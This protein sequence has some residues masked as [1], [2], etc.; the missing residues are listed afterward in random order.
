MNPIIPS[1]TQACLR[2]T[3]EDGGCRS[4]VGGASRPTSRSLILLYC[5]NRYTVVS[6]LS[7]DDESSSKREAEGNRMECVAR[8]SD[9]TMLSVKRRPALQRRLPR[10]ACTTLP[11]RQQRHL[12]SL[13]SLELVNP[14][15]VRVS[16]HAYSS[17][18]AASA[19]ICWSEIS[20]LRSVMGSECL[21]DSCCEGARK[22]RKRSAPEGRTSCCRLIPCMCGII[23][24]CKVVISLPA[25]F[26]IS[27]HLKLPSRHS[28]DVRAPD[29]VSGRQDDGSSRVKR[30]KLEP[31]SLMDGAIELYTNS[32]RFSRLR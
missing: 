17:A 27:L 19:M 23:S 26:L 22:A 6:V 5:F 2:A 13:A 20:G 15:L 29:A 14:C 32:S 12:S 21:A 18:A 1:P 30:S 25:S 28:S 16:H 9:R 8:T 3:G 31:L 11:R 7:T 24:S 4:G 10:V